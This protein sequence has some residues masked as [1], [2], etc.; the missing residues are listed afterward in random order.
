MIAAALEAEVEAYLRELSQLRDERGH[1][2][3]VR[4]GRA[5]ERTLVMGAGAVK[6]Q[7]PRVPDRRPGHRF[8]SKILPPS[9]RRSPRLEEALPVLYLRG[10]STGDFSKALGVLLGP[11]AAG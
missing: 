10:L 5:R 6:L 8:S 11:E 3:A 4:N 1:V 9:M 2:L 7:A